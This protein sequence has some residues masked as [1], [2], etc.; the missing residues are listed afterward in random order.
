[1]KM[2]YFSKN[3]GVSPQEDL[4]EK[5]IVDGQTIEFPKIEISNIDRDSEGQVT[6]YFE[7]GDF[8]LTISRDE[9]ERL[10]DS[11]KQPIT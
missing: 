11:L 4:Q 10:V 3:E 2:M 9:I 7:L 1:M 5:C 6:V 8:Y